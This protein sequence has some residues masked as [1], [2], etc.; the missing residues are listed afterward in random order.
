V[1]ITISSEVLLLIFQLSLF[2]DFLVAMAAD[3]SKDDF[4]SGERNAYLNKKVKR[5]A[6][7]IDVMRQAREVIWKELREYKIKAGKFNHLG[8]EEKIRLHS[9]LAWKRKLGYTVEL[10][11]AIVQEFAPS[12]ILAASDEVY[13]PNMFRCLLGNFT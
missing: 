3:V 13:F 4:I 5:S 7:E 2:F 9:I 10:Q 6:E 1:L 11:Y 8:M 12:K